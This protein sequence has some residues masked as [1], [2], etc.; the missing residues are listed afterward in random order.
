MIS[1]TTEEAVTQ[2]VGYFDLE[3]YLVGLSA[4]QKIQ[5][6]VEKKVLLN[7]VEE[8][9]HLENYDITPELEMMKKYNINKVS[10]AGKYKVENVDNTTTYTALEDDLITRK[11]TI[12][13]SGDDIIN[14]EITGLQKSILSESK[15]TIIFAPEKSF[16]LKSEDENKYSQDLTKEVLIEY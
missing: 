10:L 5:P 13:K 2:G 1:C 12:E 14:L 3:N 4:E 6:S 11:I 8:S 16:Y 9:K 7:G 15:Q